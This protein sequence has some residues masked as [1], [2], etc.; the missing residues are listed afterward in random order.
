M[1]A[2]FEEHDRFLA[3]S[4]VGAWPARLNGRYEAIIARHVDQLRGAR[5]LDIGSHDGRWAL[6]ALKAGAAHV[7][8]VEA[9]PELVQRAEENLT[10]YGVD[11]SRFSFLVSDMN[12]KRN[13][14]GASFDVVLCLGYFYH[15]LNHMALWQLMASTGARHLILDGTVEPTDA[16]VIA[17]MQEDISHHANGTSA[18]GV[19]GGQILVGHP[20]PS[21]LGLLCEQVGFSF[22]LVDWGPILQKLRPEAEPLRRLPSAGDPLADYAYGSRVTGLATR[23]V[24]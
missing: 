2:F 18:E 5:V 19:I 12:H 6:A 23:R 17:L 10:S 9:R 22:A 1:A 3:T 14:Q 24:L 13:V 15:T 4:E 16:P 20:S 11:G 7:T 8:G 21:A